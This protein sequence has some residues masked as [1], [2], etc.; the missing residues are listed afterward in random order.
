MFTLARLKNHAIVSDVVSDSIGTDDR[1]LQGHKNGVNV[2]FAN[3]SVQFELRGLV[4]PE[5]RRG[6]QF[7]SD[8]TGNY[9]CDEIWNNFDHDEQLYP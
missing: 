7:A 8:G 9:I 4:D 6:S 3:G 2:L 1:I 5:N